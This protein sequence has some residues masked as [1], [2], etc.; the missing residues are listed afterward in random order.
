MR[1]SHFLATN[2]GEQPA[3]SRG[4]KLLPRVQGAVWTLPR[5]L[6]SRP[7]RELL[8]L[9]EV[10]AGTQLPLSGLH[11]RST[12]VPWCPMEMAQAAPGT[13]QKP[14]LLSGPG[15]GWP[16][17]ECAADFPFA[18]QGKGPSAPIFSYCA[19]EPAICRE[20]FS[21]SGQLLPVFDVC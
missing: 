11:G 16:S 5:P 10:H 12:P 14:E 3:Y 9:C 21:L 13:R 17:K 1:F 8:C 2:S 19:H 7:A 18:A 4:S 15:T 6:G 20:P